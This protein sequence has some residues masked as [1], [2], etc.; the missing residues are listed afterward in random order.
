MNQDL[1]AL[2]FKSLGTDIHAEIVLDTISREKKEEAKADLE[3]L[4]NIYFAKQK[5]FNRFDLESEI[6]KINR[7]LKTF[8]EASADMLYLGK[9]ILHYNEISNGIFDPRVIGILENI[10]YDK[11]F[12][13]KDFS[14]ANLPKKQA[15]LGGDLEKDLAIKDGK[16][17]FGKKMDFS[18]VAKGYITDCAAKFLKNQGWENFLVDSGGDMR[19]FGKNQDDE[20][21]K[22]EIEGIPKAKLMLEITDQGIATSGISR[23]K[24]KIDGKKFHHLINPKK[25]NQFSY[26]LR[27]VSVIAKNTE[28]ADGRAKVLV[29]L[30]KENGMEFAA[31]NKIA[32]VFLDYLGNV[33]VT[34]E[35]KKYIPT[36]G[37][38]G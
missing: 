2:D 29:L 1:V 17:Y 9:R 34:S 8:Q 33:F 20:N 18:G 21:W 36:H 26:E 38:T 12:K 4:K 24:W 16:I 10:G 7:K 27:T 14:A 22:I 23:K 32:A 6:S 37:P 30:G 19:I 3:S 13:R 15:P 35:A 5:I 28:E 25:P 11:D 31:E